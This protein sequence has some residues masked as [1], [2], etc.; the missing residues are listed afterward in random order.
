MMKSLDKAIKRCRSLDII[1]FKSNNRDRTAFVRMD[2]VKPGCLESGM[3]RQ[4]RYFIPHIPQHVIARGVERQA[5][6]FQEQD[7]RLHRQ[8]NES[9]KPTLSSP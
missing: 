3:P 9:P 1:Y 8:A 7:Y 2:P 5:V 6:F 4:P